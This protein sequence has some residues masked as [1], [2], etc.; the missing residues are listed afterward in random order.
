MD[1][2]AEEAEVI[3]RACIFFSS[4]QVLSSCCLLH[5]FSSHGSR[6]LSGAPA[7]LTLRIKHSISQEIA[8][9][10]PHWYTHSETSGARQNGPLPSSI[11][12]PASSHDCSSC[13]R[14]SETTGT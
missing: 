14:G 11:S 7:R 9:F 4:Q 6:L 1:S 12:L 5:L 13:R 3:R 10:H 8:S 2:L